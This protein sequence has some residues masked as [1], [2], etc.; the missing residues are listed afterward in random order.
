MRFF[1][2]AIVVSPFKETAPVPVERVEALVWEILP[3]KETV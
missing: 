1:P 2:A 3:G